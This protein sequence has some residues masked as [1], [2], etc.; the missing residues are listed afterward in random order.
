VSD[1]ARLSL[2]EP[3]YLSV[4]EAA[5]ASTPSTLQQHWLEVP[6]AEKINTLYGFLR[7]NPKSKMIVF[8]SSA[9]QVRFVFEALKRLQ[10]GISHICLFRTWLSSCR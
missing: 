10:P 3:Q 8:L 7:A 2:Q 1:L 9:K 5:K 4:H 6:L